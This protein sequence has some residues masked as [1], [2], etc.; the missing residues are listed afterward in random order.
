MRQ[1]INMFL[2]LFAADGLIS[3]VDEMLMLVSGSSNI[4]GVRGFFANMVILLSLPVYFAL[5][6]DRRLPRIVIAPLIVFI[7]WSLLA[8]WFF[9]ALADSSIYGPLF[10]LLQLLLCLLPIEFVRR[11]G[12]EGLLLP[13]SVFKNSFFD[14][15]QTLYFA[16][17]SLLIVPA[18]S[19]LC[20]LASASAFADKATSGFVRIAP[21]G[22]YMSERIYR[23]NDRTIRLSGMI[24]VGDQQFYD[25]MGK[26]ASS[27]RTVILAEGVTDEDGLIKNRFG[28]GKMAGFLGLSSQEK[29]RL[30]GRLIEGKDIGLKS[31][32]AET[33]I[34]R[35]DI[36]TR[37]LKKE[38]LYF[39]NNIGKY[40]NE[41]ESFAATIIALNSWAEKELTPEMNNIIMSDILHMRS[42]VL[43][44]YLDKV[45][46]HYE[47]V[48]IPWGALH[49]AEIEEAVLQR[50]FVLQEKRYRES[51]DFRKMLTALSLSEK[52]QPDVQRQ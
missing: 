48:V 42:R 20:L 27:G 47:T 19:L 49:M 39:L 16:A 29:M 4:T 28:Y 8:S 43:I 11:N 23:L 21:D 18:V 30:K 41:G 3:F 25:D 13:E 50:G 10:A 35:A 26:S 38:T 32:S 36:D 34:V 51:I 44:G 2:I 24:H 33:D 14:L 40:L 37:D 52:R 15:K 5:G 6:V 7:L 12:G 1:F 22:L 45:L 31:G 9:P 46:P 17:A